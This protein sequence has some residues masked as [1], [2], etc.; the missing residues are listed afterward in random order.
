MQKLFKVSEN[1]KIKLPTFIV[2]VVNHSYSYSDFKMIFV[3]IK[4][5]S[6]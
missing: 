3:N 4:L 2:Y 5:L 1:I 6:Y